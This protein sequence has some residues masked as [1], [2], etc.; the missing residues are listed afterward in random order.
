MKAF[1]KT[2]NKCGAIK[3]KPVVPDYCEIGQRFNAPYVANEALQISGYLKFLDGWAIY[4]FRATNGEGSV[5]FFVEFPVKAFL[6]SQNHKI[7]RYTRNTICYK[8][9]LWKL[10][11]C[12]ETLLS[13]FRS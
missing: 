4:G 6:A 1:A 10:I 13:L 3:R 7:T 2:W 12:L 5:L 9:L 11:Q 8:E